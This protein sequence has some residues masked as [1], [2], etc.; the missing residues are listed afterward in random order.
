MIDAGA[1]CASAHAFLMAKADEVARSC[2]L[3]VGA[4]G[5][6]D[7]TLKCL[8]EAERTAARPAQWQAIFETL[9][10][11]GAQGS[12][13]AE[14]VC[15]RLVSEQRDDGSWEGDEP[16]HETDD[17]GCTGMLAG[18]LAKTPFVRERALR[19]AAD[20]MAERWSPDR[21]K[22]DAWEVTAAY[23]HCFSLVRHESADAILQWC[24]REL[25]RGLVTG[26]YDAVRT[27][28]VYV[29]CRA[30]ALPGAPIR[31]EELLERLVGEQSADGSFRLRDDDSRATVVGHTLD[32]LVALLHLR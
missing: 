3:V 4:D 7:D 5:T 6:P 12:G 21:V 10:I 28:R 30:L 29:W 14:R 15:Q 19:S 8:I 16:G 18:Y 20:Y 11:V 31:R 25:Q 32:A 24:G 13:M 17:M 2:A 9:D 22:G 23:C 27:A 26:V 1:A